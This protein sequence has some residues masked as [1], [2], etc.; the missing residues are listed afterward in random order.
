MSVLNRFTSCYFTFG[1][2]SAFM[3]STLI[4]SKTNVNWVLLVAT[5]LA[6]KKTA[7]IY[8]YGGIIKT[9]AKDC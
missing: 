3:E 4:L 1:V 7:H 6:R 8:V 5:E 2:E 9:S